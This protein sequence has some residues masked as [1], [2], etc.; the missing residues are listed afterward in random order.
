MISGSVPT[1]TANGATIPAIGFGT[2][3]IE[4]D[5]CIQCVEHA[6]KTGYNHIDTAAAYGNEAEV[7]KGIKASGIPR[8]T[9]FI[10]TKIWRSETSGSKLIKAAEESLRK[11]DIAQLD[12]LLL[13]WPTPETPLSETI[14]ALC[15]AKKDGLTRHIGVSNYPVKL[16]EE[17]IALASE[18]IVTDQCEY[19]PFLDQSK[20]REACFKHG[21]FFTSYSPLGHGA[22][23]EDTAIA[24]IAQ[25][26]NKT[27]AQV[28]L[29]WHLQQPQT[30]VIPKSK[31]LKRIEENFNIFNFELTSNQ[32]S[33]ISAL[34][35]EKRR[36]VNPSFAPEWD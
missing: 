19:H 3:Q 33:A 10:T 11:L 22:S 16:L 34:L 2:W 28:I 23:W 26:L 7:G 27:P 20:L 1:I 9:I 35:S 14:Q 4:G 21:M 12:L 17:S 24:S 36:M 8:D 30:V 15:K 6:L 25:Q 32:M 5:E 18:P 13:H 31:S 29:R